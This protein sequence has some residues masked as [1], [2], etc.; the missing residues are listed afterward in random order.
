M[1]GKHHQVSEFML[2]R[3][4]Y[5]AALLSPPIPDREELKLLLTAAARVPD[6][7]MLVP[8]RF[9]VIGKGAMPRLAEQL[10][11]RGGALGKAPSL[12]NKAAD[13]FR[14][15]NLV[16][17]VV[18]SPDSESKFPVIEQKLSA[19]AVCLSLLNAA[20]AR[21]WGAT[22]VTGFG[23]HDPEYRES[24][25]NLAPNEFIAG[26]VHIGTS[27]NQ[28][29]ERPRPGIDTITTWLDK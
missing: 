9:I 13:V 5:P 21:G 16:V 8:W 3:R 7:G 14:K 23:A 25:L 20:L 11:K 1:P 2:T 24:V 17:A 27:A 26:F 29:P 10:V 4:S 18:A 22:W 15:A 19:G 6:H 28:P 12:V